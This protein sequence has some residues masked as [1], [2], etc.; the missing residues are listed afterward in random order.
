ME[1][2]WYKRGE[3]KG[4]PKIKRVCVEQ[5]VK[6]IADFVYT[7]NGKKVV[8][9][10]FDLLDESK[11]SLIEANKIDVANGNGFELN[12]N[13]LLGLRDVFQNS[14]DEIYIISNEYT[15]VTFIDYYST[16]KN[17]HLHF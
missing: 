5:S 4:Q 14:E 9:T 1:V 3:L 15:E 16:L 2:L 13:K 6:Y 10:I 8:D 11:E 17:C 12:I 7:E